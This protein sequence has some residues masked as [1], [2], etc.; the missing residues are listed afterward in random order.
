MNDTLENHAVTDIPP[1]KKRIN[2][3]ASSRL[4]RPD[5]WR[6]PKLTLAEAAIQT[7]L[8]IKTLRNNLGTQELP[9]AAVHGPFKINKTDLDRFVS[10][11]SRSQCCRR[12]KRKTL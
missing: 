6:Q 12:G 7:G 1:R 5:H 10:G 4:V 11:E 2:P 9:C 8:S 3:M